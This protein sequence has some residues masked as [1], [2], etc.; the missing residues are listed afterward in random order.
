MHLRAMKTYFD[1]KM[2]PLCGQRLHAGCRGGENWSIIS[3][4]R[5][6][7]QTFANFLYKSMIRNIHKNAIIAIK[8]WRGYRISMKSPP[9]HPPRSARWNGRAETGWDGLRRA[10]GGAETVGR[11]GWGGPRWSETRRALTADLAALDGQI[12]GQLGRKSVTRKTGPRRHPSHPNPQ[13]TRINYKRNSNSKKMNHVD[14]YF[15]QWCLKRSCRRNE[16]Q[17]RSRKFD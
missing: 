12:L 14:P 7:N 13:D 11:T 1:E 17:Q 5:A 3:I 4:Y 10:D 6:V 2:A 9:V 8:L 15:R 16:R